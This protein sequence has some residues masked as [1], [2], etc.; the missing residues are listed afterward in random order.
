MSS[1]VSLSPECSGKGPQL[2]SFRFDIALARLDLALFY[3]PE[4]ASVS[5]GQ[6]PVEFSSAHTCGC[7]WSSLA[8]DKLVAG[9]I[10][11]ALRSS[12]NKRNPHLRPYHRSSWESQLGGI[13]PSC[14]IAGVLHLFKRSSGQVVLLLY[15][16]ASHS[17][18]RPPSSY[19]RPSF[20][21]VFRC[22]GVDK[23]RVD[24]TTTLLR[25]R[26]RQTSCR[27]LCVS[28]KRIRSANN[29]LCARQGPGKANSSSVSLRLLG[30]VVN[31]TRH[32]DLSL[33]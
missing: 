22:Q 28:G 17:P 18:S 16:F 3:R 26:S 30:P 7:T 9:G 21:V 14:R 12:A 6:A 20:T 27:S 23:G 33:P 1:E 32:P 13:P 2:W 10:C 5:G 8:S 4:I 11:S 15:L 19:S 25:Q 24:R 31:L 29:G